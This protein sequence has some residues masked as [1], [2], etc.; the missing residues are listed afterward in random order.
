M[1]LCYSNRTIRCQRN[2]TCM[3][4]CPSLLCPFESKFPSYCST[5]HTLFFTEDSKQCANPLQPAH[6]A[7]HV[8]RAR[9]RTRRPLPRVDA[10]LHTHLAP[11]HVC[12]PEQRLTH[13]SLHSHTPERDVVHRAPTG[14]IA[15]QPTRH[16]HRTGRLTRPHQWPQ[17]AKP[18]CKT[19][20]WV[21][22]SSQ[23]SCLHLET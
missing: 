22:V 16:H 11:R 2:L 23:M 3:L 4:F 12:T 21:A 8:P 17:W 19:P 15:R 1:H 18:H 20:S 7:A 5:P 6:L 10:A 13:P 14:Y 9:T